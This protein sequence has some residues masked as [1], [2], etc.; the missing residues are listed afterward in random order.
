VKLAD[1]LINYSIPNGNV[2]QSAQNSIMYQSSSLPGEFL[3]VLM[4]SVWLIVP[5]LITFVVLIGY[6]LIKYIKAAQVIV[7]ELEVGTVF[8]RREGDFLRFLLP[9]RG[10]HWIKPFSEKAGDKIPLG[11]QSTSGTCEELRT[12]EGIPLSIDYNVSFSVDPL[13][14]PPGIH[15]KMARALP[16]YA[17]NMVSGRVKHVLRHLV[18]QKSID[19]LYQ[20]DAVKKLEEAVRAEVSKRSAVI[21]VE[22]ISATNMKLG[23]IRMPPQVEKALKSD[24]ERKLQTATSIEALERLHAVVSKFGEADMER[25]S[26]LERL[27][28]IENS[29]SLVYLMDSLVKKVRETAVPN[30]NGNVHN[31]HN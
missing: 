4:I 26:E 13:A 19:E 9:K 15:N 2:E 14:T 7:G 29:G 25:L 1:A 8:T 12:K 17:P 24:Y 23:P 16:K 18:E 22:S 20:E 31:S 21:G 3:E 10:P 27:R 5:L 6:G 30:G 11:S 28:I